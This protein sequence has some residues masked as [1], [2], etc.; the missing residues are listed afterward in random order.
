MKHIV[1]F[2][3]LAAISV[4]ASTEP[5]RLEESLDAM[6]TTYSVVIYGSDRYKL[7]AAA[8]AAFDEA[9]RLDEML[10]NYRQESEWSTVNREAAE[11]PV[12]V[13]QELFDLLSY[14]V[15]VSARSDGAFDI[16]VGPLMKVWKM[17][18]NRLPFFGTLPFLRMSSGAMRTMASSGNEEKA[19]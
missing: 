4:Q 5:L 17:V 6:G 7:M 3:F 10:S 9:S 18:K 11:H 8:E 16:S 2:L 12:H 13:S 1:V 19:L 14:C 15:D